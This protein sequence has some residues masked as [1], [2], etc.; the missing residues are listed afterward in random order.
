MNEIKV[1]PGDIVCTRNENLFGVGIRCVEKI[2]SKDD[3]AP[4]NHVLII[5]DEDG[6]T[7]E[8]LGTIKR[9]NLFVDYK[10]CLVSVFRNDWMN[11][12]R[13]N[14]GMAKIAHHDGD[15]YPAWRLVFALIPFIAKRVGTG[16][17]LVCSELAAKFLCGCGFGSDFMPYLGKTPDDIYDMCTKYK[18][19]T[20]IA[21]CVV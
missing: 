15:I 14:D 3:S 10:G 12:K 16:E 7:L 9:Q 2:W 18:F 11:E 5:T 13:F 17:N 4:F 1:N 21:E 20:K 6:G 8:A 19:W